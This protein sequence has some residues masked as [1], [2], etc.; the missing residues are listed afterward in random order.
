MT[1]PRT[2]PARVAELVAH[3][4]A[5]ER[6]RQAS[7]VLVQRYFE[8]WNHGD[9]ALADALLGPTYVDHAHPDFVGPAATRSLVP[10]VHARDPAAR[11]AI[12]VVSADEEFV[13]VHTTETRTSEGNALEASGVA[14]FRIESG[15]LVEQWSWSPPIIPL[16]FGDSAGGAAR[17][18][19][20]V[21]ETADPEVIL[22]E[23]D[24]HRERGLAR[25][26]P[27]S[28]LYVVR[29]RE[30]EVTVLKELFESSFAPA[31]PP[32]P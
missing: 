17:Q 6:V 32:L 10:R 25:L 9:G 14:L 30:G 15:K 5:R 20:L 16:E 21:H 31:A 22:V 24:L 8:M 18:R 11:W 29:V 26:R 3:G 28:Y 4:G 13:A 19:V 23:F 2:S 27:A 1:E 7:T 12:E